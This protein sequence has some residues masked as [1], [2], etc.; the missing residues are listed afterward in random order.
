MAAIDSTLVVAQ[1]VTVFIFARGTFF[2]Q[3]PFN[4]F[5]LQEENILIHLIAALQLPTALLHG[6]LNAD[7]TEMMLFASQATKLGPE[8]SGDCVAADSILFM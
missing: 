5:R 1:L 4:D 6:L 2:L 8:C 7:A 3:G